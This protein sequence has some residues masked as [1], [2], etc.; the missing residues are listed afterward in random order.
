ME[1]KSLLRSRLRA[2]RQA[3]VE[4]LPAAT[5]ALILMRPPAPV[6]ALVPEGSIVG[7]YHATAFEAPTGG[8]ARWFAEN[9]RSLALPWF[10]GRDAPMMFREWRDPFELS[11]LVAGP[12]GALQPE[13]A[14]REVVPDVAFVPLL[15]FTAAGHRIGQGGGHYDRW[16]SEHPRTVA[17]GLAWDSQHCESLPQEAH[18]RRLAAVVTPTRIYEEQ[19]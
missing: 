10:A 5:R 9:G 8:Y 2:E 19:V 18:D 12:W 13:P 1:E 16:L 4:A 6:A 3:H 11:D 17:I 14:A 15:G 7:I